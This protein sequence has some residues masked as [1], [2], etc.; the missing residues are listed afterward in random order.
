MILTSLG[1]NTKSA[2]STRSMALTKDAE[3]D[4]GKHKSCAGYF[5][6]DAVWCMTVDHQPLMPFSANAT[7]ATT[8]WGREGLLASFNLT[9]T[10]ITA[11]NPGTFKSFVPTEDWFRPDCDQ[12]PMLFPISTDPKHGSLEGELGWNCTQSDDD[13]HALVMDTLNDVLYEQWRVVDA[14]TANPYQGGCLRIWKPSSMRTTLLTDAQ[15]TSADGSGQPMWPLVLTPE[16]VARGDIGHAL[17]FVLPNSKI[18]RRQFI[19]PATHSTRQT[20]A[21]SPALPYGAW[22]RLKWT[23]AQIDAWVSVNGNNTNVAT[24]LRGLARYGMILS[25]GGRIAL[26]MASDT[27]RTVKWADLGIHALSMYGNPPILPVDF[28]WIVPPPFSEPPPIITQDF[29]CARVPHTAPSSQP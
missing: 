22:L 18:L 10:A 26:T 19:F 15:C 23:P 16:D 20:S 8:N 12:A 13:C 11:D 17:R 14:Q 7:A 2:V 9:L 24:I 1:C 21:A 29:N 27:N 6:A 25:D 5:P 4:G 3:N 28:D